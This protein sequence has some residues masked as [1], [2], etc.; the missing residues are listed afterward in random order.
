MTAVQ[1]GAHPA[2]RGTGAQSEGGS[3][4][5]LRRIELHGFKIFAGGAGRAP[6]GMAEVQLTLENAGGAL[7]L[8]FAEVEIGRRAYRSGESEY[9]LNRGGVRL[10]DV[11]DVLSRAGI[12][13]HGHSVIGQGLV[14]LALSLRPEERRLLFEDA[15]GQRRFQ[16]KRDE[17]DAKLVE[18]R[19]NATRVADVIAELEPRLAY[20]QRQARR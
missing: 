17:A 16:A 13:Q 18:V 19:T 4:V 14:N 20:L 5:R 7:P 10:R 9:Y 12:G 8:D 1:N 2:V 6:L 11:V 3:R 15:G